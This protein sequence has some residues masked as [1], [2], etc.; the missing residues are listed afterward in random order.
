MARHFGVLQSTKEGTIRRARVQE[1]G[2]KCIVTKK[3]QRKKIVLKN[4]PK[5]QVNKGEER[6]G[7]EREGSAVRQRRRWRS[8]QSRA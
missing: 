1:K 4:P 2:N 6:G 3:S 8:G 7:D 5:K